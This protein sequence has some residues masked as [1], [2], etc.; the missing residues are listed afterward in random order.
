[1]KMLWF[2]TATSTIPWPF[3]LCGMFQAL[4]DSYLGVQYWMYGAGPSAGVPSHLGHSHAHT[5]HANGNGHVLKSDGLS[6]G[7]GITRSRTPS[8]AIFVPMTM[9]EKEERL[10]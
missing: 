3:K 1:M 2:F 4:C 8:N 6:V 5:V 10:D 9:S 7:A